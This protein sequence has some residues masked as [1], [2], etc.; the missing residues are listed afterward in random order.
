LQQAN[1]FAMPD[2]SSPDSVPYVQPRTRDSLWWELR[3][4]TPDPATPPARDSTAEV[5]SY[6][7]IERD[8][9]NVFAMKSMADRETMIR[10]WIGV[11]GGTRAAAMTRLVEQ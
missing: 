6:D 4:A 11:H 2:R 1:L 7:L 10:T 9:K 5:A 3:S 8:S